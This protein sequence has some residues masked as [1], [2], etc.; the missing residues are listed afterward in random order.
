MAGALVLAAPALAVELNA[1]VKGVVTDTDGL[2]IPGVE[3]TLTSPE[4]LGARTAATD[5]DGRYWFTALPPGNYLLVA[6]KSRFQQQNITNIRMTAG[7]TM[8]VDLELLFEDEAAIDIV[9]TRERPAVDVESTRTGAVLEAEFLANLPSGRDYQS[10]MSVVAG[11]VGGGN[12]NIHGGFDSSNQ[13]Y[14]DG[15]NI[16]DPVTNTF[17]VNMNYDA[18]E[19]LDVMTGGMDA[20][21][22]RA[23]GGAVNIVTKS[24]GNDFHG[25]ANVI[26]A[27]TWGIIAPQES[28]D[29]EDQR[30][31]QQLALN[32]GGPILKDRVWFFASI[33]AD[34][35][36]DTASFDPVEI[37]RDISR[38]PNAARDFRSMYWFGKIT[39]QVNPANRVWVHLQGEPTR[40]DNV[41]Q[42]PYTM[43]SAETYQDQ[44]G[45]L[46]SVGHTL[47]PSDR[48]V[49]ESQ[50]Y[51]QSSYIEY[52]SMLWRDCE[53]R[54][55]RG[56]CVDDFVGDT[57]AGQPVPP[58]MQ[59]WNATDFAMGEFPYAYFA[60][61]TRMSA[62]SSLSVFF[63]LLGEHRFKT[64][65]QL[66]ALGS[67]DSFPG[68]ETGI[69]YFSVAEGGDPNEPGDYEPV[70][71]YRYDS[72]LSVTLG[73]ILGSWY[74]QDVYK[75]TQRLTVRPGLRFDYTQLRAPDANG[76][77]GAAFSRITTAPRM[78]VAYDFSGDGRT[79][80]HVY[81][82]RFYDSSFLTIADLLKK[83]GGGGYGQY[84]WDP[85]ALD[86]STEADF[87]VADTF[88]QHAPLRNPYSDEFSFGLSQALGKRTQI[89]GTLIYEEA[90]R[91]WEDDEVNLIWNDDGTDVI[92]SRNGEDEAIYRFRTPDS[93]Y[94]QYTSFELEVLRH[95]D[96]WTL[97][98]SYTWAHAWGTQSGDQATGNLDTPEQRAYEVGYLAYDRRHAVKLAGN[99][100]KDDLISAG[101]LGTG[102]IFGWNYQSLS[103]TP[104]RPLLFNS[105]LGDYAN[106]DRPGDQVDRLPW[107]HTLD[108]RTALHFDYAKKANWTVGVDIFNLFNS[109]QVTSV[110]TSFDP[111]ATGADQTYG[112]ALDRLNRRRL[113][114]VVRGA[115]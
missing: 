2:P 22:G 15:V 56:V 85:D 53:E 12:A 8:L 69:P 66:E 68:L 39:A 13:F 17:S 35:A 6:K 33:Q 9:V 34:R 45:F 1:T 90:H 43:P 16:T 84:S 76:D 37:G 73:G 38:Y 40:I 47:T 78:G 21:Y 62:T 36:V 51:Y 63:D 104:Y 24:G 110:N 96:A 106:Y 93:A 14:I 99:W 5:D 67:K 52:A 86:W 70:A 114:L 58:S 98:G 74:I 79:A 23:L 41:E 65:V 10:A 18:I 108:V 101:R 77:L 49:L 31:E 54:D 28:Y 87:T 88:L 75:P 57:Y 82:G 25:S 26:Y 32:L 27:P 81:Y 3:V 94:T 89:D 55:D 7:A 71:L 113:Q 112:E 105:Y 92:G 115:F 11:V 61:R 44:G 59:P 20:E 83:Q 29:S 72:D 91:F 97:L 80:G 50:L 100:V 111:E 102:F 95:F 103:G 42:T 107:Q 19:S 64:G 48:V 60:K 109:R 4:M 30:V 46:A